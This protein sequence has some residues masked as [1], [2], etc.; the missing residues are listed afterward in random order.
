MRIS[1]WSS[2]VCSSDLTPFLFYAARRLAPWRLVFAP[3][4]LLAMGLYA[5]KLITRARLKE[6]NQTL[7]LG[8]HLHPAEL[9]PVAAGFARHTTE[10]NVYP[11]ALDRIAADK[12]DGW[13]AVLATASYRLYVGALAED[14]KST[15]LNSSH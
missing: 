12:A 10:T 2:D 1:D 3:F 7:L 8:H 13:R 9:K 15:R 5:A 4:A 6:W 14:R 11:H